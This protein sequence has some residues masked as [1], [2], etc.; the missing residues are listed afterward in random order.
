MKKAFS[1]LIIFLLFLCVVPIYANTVKWI[2]TPQYDQIE[3]YCDGIYLY[4]QGTQVGLIDTAGKIISGSECEQ[5]TPCV[6]NG[7]SLLLENVGDQEAFLIG[8]FTKSHK[9]ISLREKQF[10]IKQDYAFFSD[11][12]LPVKDKNGKWGYIDIEGN[13]VIPC[14]YNKALPF[15]SE[16]APV[17]M[18]SKESK[19][20]NP[21]GASTFPNGIKFNKG[22]FHDATPFFSDGTA[23]VAFNNGSKVAR[24]N[25]DGETESTKNVKYRGVKGWL[26]EYRTSLEKASSNSSSL[27]IQEALPLVVKE[28][29]KI[30]G[31]YNDQAIVC[32]N[33]KMGILQLLHGDFILGQPTPSP[34]KGK[35]Q[36]KISMQLE[37]PGG[38]SC[39]DL[40]FEVD[41]GDGEMRV[42]EAKDYQISADS[43]AV[44]FEFVPNAKADSKNVTLRLAVKD[45]DLTVFNKSD[46]QVQIKDPDPIP[47]ICKWCGKRHNGKHKRCGKCGLYTDEVLPDYKCEAN[48]AHTQCDYP[49]CKKWHFKKYGP[50]YKKNQCPGNHPRPK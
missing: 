45:H 43:K 14:I 12:R 35:K 40:T 41:K 46:M 28:Q 29:L 38:L 8:I 32:M 36:T 27:D 22:I 13:N 2:I 20:I 44:T 3:F 11:G 26:S 42:A 25:R 30:V 19:Y 15:F 10:K 6:N 9:V 33:C 5:I 50:G 18:E 7:F 49:K 47:D 4:H 23:D 24:I 37:I 31:T 16:C 21:D 48:G 34:P 39:N 1:Q 17:Q